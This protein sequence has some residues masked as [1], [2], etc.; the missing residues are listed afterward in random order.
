MYWQPKAWAD[1]PTCVKWAKG[2]LKPHVLEKHKGSDGELQETLIFLDDL[3]AQ[4]QDTYRGGGGDSCS[5]PRPP[6]PSRPG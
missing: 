1:R 6:N 4:L 2:T 3:D 5:P